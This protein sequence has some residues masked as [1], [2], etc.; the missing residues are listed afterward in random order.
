VLPSLSRHG[1]KI[2]LPERFDLRICHWFTRSSPRNVIVAAAMPASTLH[3]A[4][5]QKKSKEAAA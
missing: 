4:C 5:P 3:F 1:E 2:I